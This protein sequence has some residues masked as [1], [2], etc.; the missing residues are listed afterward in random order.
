MSQYQ[1]RELGRVLRFAVDQVPAYRHLRP[2]VERHKPYEAIRAF[3]LLDKDTV[4]ARQ[5]DYLPRDFQKIP[6]YETTTGG[7]SGNQLKIYVDDCSQS[8][9]L[10][11]MHRQW[12]RVGYTPRQRKATFR[13]VSFPNLKPGVFWQHNPIYNELQFSPFHMSQANLAAYVNE[14]IGLHRPISTV[15]LRRSTSWRS[16]S[17]TTSGQSAL[18]R[19]HR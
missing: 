6:H 11:F 10:G 2:V 3:P 13:G 18:I 7:T 15:I 12:L 19:P 8:V 1:E 5:A 9:E 16:M 17:A 4:Q 14:I